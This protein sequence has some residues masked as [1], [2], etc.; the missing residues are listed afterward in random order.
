MD[1]TT[2]TT[3]P[4][5]PSQPPRRRIS[6]LQVLALVGV[7][8]VILIIAGI[9]WLPTISGYF[10]SKASFRELAAASNAAELREACYRK[11]LGT[12]FSFDDGSWIAVS[13]RDSHGGAGFSSAIALD[14]K[15]RWYS[16]EFHFCGMFLGLRAQQAER[17]ELGVLLSENRVTPD[18]KQAVIKQLADARAYFAGNHLGNS[19]RPGAVAL[20]ATL[21]EAVVKLREAGFEDIEGPTSNFRGELSLK[22]AIDPMRL[23]RSDWVWAATQPH[24]ASQP[25]DASVR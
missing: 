22:E 3:P 2:T 6:P 9:W 15:G 12:I 24:A 7:G 20:A 16:S 17:Y 23:G 4:A 8:L 21:D 19:P 13:Y 25:G 18:M 14:S 10:A 5:A 1:S 11:S